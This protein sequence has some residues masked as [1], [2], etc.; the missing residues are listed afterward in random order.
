M[1]TTT[2]AL[3][4]SGAGPF[5]MRPR[6]IEFLTNAIGLLLLVRLFHLVLKHHRDGIKWVV[7]GGITYWILAG[8]CLFALDTVLEGGI[9]LALVVVNLA[10]LVKRRQWSHPRIIL[11]D[12]TLCFCLSQIAVP[13]RWVGFSYNSTYGYSFGKNALTRDGWAVL[14]NMV[15]LVILLAAFWVIERW[16]SNQASHAT[17]E[18]V[19]GAVS[20]AHGG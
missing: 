16:H 1:I 3:M 13:G 18:P 8:V 7:V 6:A 20:S 10:I 17:S 12:M 19:P 11:L 5:L 9:F 4:A 15:I 14:L 2:L